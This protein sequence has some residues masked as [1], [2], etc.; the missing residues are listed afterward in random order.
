M[1]LKIYSNPRSDGFDKGR[2]WVGDMD[3]LSKKPRIFITSIKYGN[4]LTALS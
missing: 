3:E 4:N 1:P 2:N